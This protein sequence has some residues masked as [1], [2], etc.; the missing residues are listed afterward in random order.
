MLRKFGSQASAELKRFTKKVEAEAGRFGKKVEAELGRV[1]DRI[2]ERVLEKAASTSEQEPP[3]GALT[4][5]EL[6]QTEEN[7]SVS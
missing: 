4:A 1:E 5:E 2:A 3:Q 7:S 6:G